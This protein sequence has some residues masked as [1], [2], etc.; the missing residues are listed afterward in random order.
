[1]L[2]VSSSC[3]SSGKLITNPLAEEGSDIVPVS[4]T[5]LADGILLLIPATEDED[6]DDDCANAA[7]FSKV[8]E[9]MLI[10]IIYKIDDETSIIANIIQAVQVNACL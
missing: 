10:C 6:K 1:L 5:D 4:K 2:A 3:V 7:L 9:I 8:F